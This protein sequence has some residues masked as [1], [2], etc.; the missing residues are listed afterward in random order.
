[1]FSILRQ[2]LLTIKLKN[3][4]SSGLIFAGLQLIHNKSK[5]YVKLNSFYGFK[6]VCSTA[7]VTPMHFTALLLVIDAHNV[8]NSPLP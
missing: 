7:G 1:M 5:I 8:P 4:V 2:K 3:I 6:F